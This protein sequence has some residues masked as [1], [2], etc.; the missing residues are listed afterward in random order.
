MRVWRTSGFS[1]GGKKKRCNDLVLCSMVKLVLDIIVKAFFL[2][3]L[4]FFPWK[5]LLKQWQPQSTRELFN[6]EF[7]V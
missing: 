6:K 4:F 1:N 7:L 5:L 3:F 2:S